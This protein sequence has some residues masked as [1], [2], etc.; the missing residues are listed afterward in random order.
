MCKCYMKNHI[1]AIRNH[2]Q[3]EAHKLK[4]AERE[5]PASARSYFH[6]EG[7]SLAAVMRDLASGI[8]NR[9]PW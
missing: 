1:A 5:R 8:L 4:V 3:G 6:A 2:E 7:R 9:S